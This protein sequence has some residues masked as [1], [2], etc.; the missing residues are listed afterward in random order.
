MRPCS[1]LAG[2]APGAPRQELFAHQRIKA[3]NTENKRKFFFDP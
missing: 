1:G 3:Q 2:L